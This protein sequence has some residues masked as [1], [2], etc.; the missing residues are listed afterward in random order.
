MNT[1]KAVT[2]RLTETVRYAAGVD[3]PAVDDTVLVKPQRLRYMLET[4]LAGSARRVRVA[5]AL[6][7]RLACIERLDRRWVLADLSGQPHQT[8]AWPAWSTGRPGRGQ[9]PARP[10]TRRLIVPTQRGGLHPCAEGGLRE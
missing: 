7:R 1:V 6:D 9:Q 3:L 10:D 5:G 2:L 8:R 4:A